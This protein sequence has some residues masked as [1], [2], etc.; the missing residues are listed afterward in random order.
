MTD[1]GEQTIEPPK[2]EEE[3]EDDEY[4]ANMEKFLNEK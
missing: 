1:G 2:G 3:P 4:E